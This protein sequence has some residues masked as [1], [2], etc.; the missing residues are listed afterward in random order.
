MAA[1]PGNQ[2]LASVEAGADLSNY[3]LHFVKF[4]G[5]KIVPCSAATDVPMG[6]LQE[7]VPSGR[8][9]EVIVVGFT[10]VEAGA[11][12][13]SGAL[14]GTGATAKADAKTPGTDTTEYVV[15]TLWEDAAASGDLVLAVV[16]CA[17]PHRAS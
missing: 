9:G 3:A 2:I 16:D 1:V 11:A 12:I 13:T 8:M 5:G 4:S 15:G 17:A 7:G 6:V 14:I 10:L